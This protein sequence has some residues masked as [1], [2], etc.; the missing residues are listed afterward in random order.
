[1]PDDR[2]IQVVFDRS[3]VT[4]FMAQSVA[5]GEM[6]AVIVEDDGSFGVP[7]PVLAE[8]SRRRRCTWTRKASLPTV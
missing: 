5:V 4:A 7:V 8:A 2:P 1:V 6:I 3:A